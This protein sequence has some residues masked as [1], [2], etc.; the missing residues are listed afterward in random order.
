MI[1]IYLIVCGII[2]TSCSGKIEKKSDNGYTDEE[3]VAIEFA[4][5]MEEQEYKYKD[6]HQSEK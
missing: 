3:L 5:R 6:Y 4:T 1:R 2:L